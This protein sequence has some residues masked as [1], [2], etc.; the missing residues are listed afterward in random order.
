M[1]IFNSIPNTII[2]GVV[3]AVVLTFVVKAI[4]GL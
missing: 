4:A 1:F 2:A 3:L